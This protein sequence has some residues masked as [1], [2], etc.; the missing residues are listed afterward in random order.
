MVILATNVSS[1][2]GVQWS[3]LSLLV[4]PKP[5]SVKGWDVNIVIP[6]RKEYL[7]VGGGGDVWNWTRDINSWLHDN[8]WYC[9]ILHAK[10]FTICQ[11]LLLQME[12]YV[13]DQY[14]TFLGITNIKPFA[15]LI[16]TF[17]KTVF[18]CLLWC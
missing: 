3:P 6:D 5:L 9:L 12:I 10:C 15:Y 1:P 18:C 17:L 11:I 8:S 13:Y 7:I 14:K 4:S 2:S 16:R